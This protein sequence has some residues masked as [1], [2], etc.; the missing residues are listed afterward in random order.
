MGIEIERRFLVDGRNAKPWQDCESVIPMYQCYL[1]GVAHVDGVIS[2]SGVSLVNADGPIENIATWRIRKQ[3]DECVLT[4]KGRRFGASA[5]EHE[6]PISSD[7]FDLITNE[8]KLPSTRKS[9]FLWRGNDG[10][11]WEIDEFEDDLAGLIIAEVE[12][13]DENQAVIIPDWVGMELTNLKGWSNA[14]LAK[15]IEDAKRF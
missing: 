3:G 13:D 7:V 15:M 14:N 2:Y 5:I 12:L 8:E 4:A 10:L 1:S 11:L 9:R 6:W